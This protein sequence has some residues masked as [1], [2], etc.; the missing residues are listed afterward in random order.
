MLWFRF[1]PWFPCRFYFHLFLGYRYRAVNPPYHQILRIDR[2]GM[3]DDVILHDKWQHLCQKCL[4]ISIDVYSSNSSYLATLLLKLQW[5]TRIYEETFHVNSSSNNAKYLKFYGR[6][7]ESTRN[8]NFGDY[9]GDISHSN[10][11]TGRYGPNFKVSLIIRESWQ[12]CRYWQCMIMGLNKIYARCVRNNCQKDSREAVVHIRTYDKGWMQKD[13]KS[14]SPILD[15][16]NAFL[17]HSGFSLRI[18]V[19]G[20]RCNLTGEYSERG[21]TSE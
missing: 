13:E 21:S 2:E 11:E 6:K 20:E 10:L 9:P 14:K 1:Y 18:L 19:A 17:C 4:L 15:N 5:H 7:V 16:S 8:S 12:H 3:I